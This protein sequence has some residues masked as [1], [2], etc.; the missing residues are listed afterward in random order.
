M[1]ARM[2]LLVCTTSATMSC[3]QPNVTSAAVT[4][5]AVTPTVSVATAEPPGPKCE[6]APA[7]PRRAPPPKAERARMTNARLGAALESASSVM[8]GELGRWQLEA[9]GVKMMCL[10]DEV[11]DRMRIV[12]AITEVSKMTPDQRDRIMSANFHSALDA[13]YA[14]RDGVLFSAFIHPLSPLSKEEVASAVSQVAELA[15]TFGT[16]YSSGALTFGR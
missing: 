13:R 11:H 3:H 2:M 1:R 4:S 16:T 15:K 9:S 6:E 8:Q 12:A 10:T 14:V 5:A 7:R